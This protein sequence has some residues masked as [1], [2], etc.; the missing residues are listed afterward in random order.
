[1]A[2]AFGLNKNGRLGIG[3]DKDRVDV[4]TPVDIFV[5]VR[6]FLNEPEKLIAKQSLCGPA[7]I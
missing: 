1:M 7:G 5:E 2:M 6:I 3:S 4:M